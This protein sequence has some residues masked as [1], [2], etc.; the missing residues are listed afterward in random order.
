[1]INLI[2]LEQV[3]STNTYAKA[4]LKSGE[5][6]CP[7]TVIYAKEQTAGRG[8]LGREWHSKEGQSLCMSL[9]VPYH[10]KP[11][12]T[13]LC[14]LGV[15]KA[16][17][18]ICGETHREKLRIKW[19]NDIIAG[20]KK[21]CGIL[22]EGTEKASIIG[23]GINLNSIDFPQDIAHKATSLKLMTGKDSEPLEIAKAVAEEV[24]SIT[25]MN[26]GN[27]TEDAIKKYSPLCANISREVHF[28][29]KKGIAVGIAE[30]G[31]LAVM[32]DG[33]LEKV[34]FGEVTVSGIY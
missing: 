34:S 5:P 22:V 30:D 32:T 20:S 2:C 12:I 15:H 1:M 24:F 8:R 33:S 17:E 19:P 23:I 16:L 29:G 9:I 26:Q 6:L 3:D 18:K 21:L 28:G 11:G 7:Y 25:D 31:S 27:L 13:L 14:A 4:L 10:H